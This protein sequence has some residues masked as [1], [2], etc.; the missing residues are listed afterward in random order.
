M[1]RVGKS[2]TYTMSNACT[3]VEQIARHTNLSPCVLISLQ[4]MHGGSGGGRQEVHP[5][6]S[7]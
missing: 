6:E 2:H 7:K 4:Q 5:E 1:Q 3:Q